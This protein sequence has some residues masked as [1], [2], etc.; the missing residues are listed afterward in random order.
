MEWA[1]DEWEDF[2]SR[3][4][5]LP[6]NPRISRKIK[7]FYFP[8]NSDFTSEL[9]STDLDVFDGLT[10]IFSDRVFFSSHH[11]TAL[12]HA[13]HSPV[14]TYIFSHQGELDLVPF[15]WA[16]RGEMLGHIV[17]DI[18]LYYLQ[19]WIQRYLKGLDPRRYGVCHGEEMT[20]QFSAPIVPYHR[21]NSPDFVMSRSFIKAWV[22]FA[23]DE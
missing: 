5:H 15:L 10:N 16:L 14:Y 1:L 23:Y 20:Y 11:Q 9:N 21:R 13:P 3:M 17:T 4:L 19:D 18:P 7:N 2:I 12:L 6:K 8:D 22:D